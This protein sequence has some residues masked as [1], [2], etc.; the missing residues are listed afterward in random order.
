MTKITLTKAQS[1]IYA[2]ILDY[3]EEYGE[4]PTYP[5]IMEYSGYAMTTVIYRL[6]ELVDLGLITR[7]PARPRSIRL[8]DVR[9]P[10]FE[11]PDEPLAETPWTDTDKEP[12][13][14]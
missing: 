9:L 2:A 7:I 13:V 10:E 6:P 5:E 12:K 1:A 8:T 4:S 11:L 3:I 14:F